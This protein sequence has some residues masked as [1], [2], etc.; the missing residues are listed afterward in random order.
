MT[1]IVFTNKDYQK[2]T[3]REWAAIEIYH[4]IVPVN[5]FSKQEYQISAVSKW[6]VLLKETL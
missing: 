5:V 2:R 4:L 6:R 1:K 3:L